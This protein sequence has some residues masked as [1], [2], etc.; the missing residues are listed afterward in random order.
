VGDLDGDGKNDPV[1]SKLG[2]VTT[3]GGQVTLTKASVSIYYAGSSLNCWQKAEVV[4]AADGLYFPNQTTLFD[5]DGDGDL[6]IV[7]PFGFFVCQFDMAAG[8]CGALAWFENKSTEWVRHDVVPNG[9]DDFYHKVILT[10]FDDGDLDAASAEF[11]VTYQRK[12]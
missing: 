11:F 4:T 10:D 6:D 2:A 12:N 5:V 1:I 8:K 9:S 3:T 7:I